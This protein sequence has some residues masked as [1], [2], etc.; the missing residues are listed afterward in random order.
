M[1]DAS[2]D[3]RLAVELESRGRNAVSAKRLGLDRLQDD[4][5]LPRLVDL[6]RGLD[7]MLITSDDNMPAEHGGLITSLGGIT[8]ATIDGQ[9]KGHGLEQEQWKCEVVHRW[10]HV[11]H[12]QDPLTI[13]RY[14]QASHRLWTPRRTRRKPIGHRVRSRQRR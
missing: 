3:H 10:V 14:S 8:V 13:R 4:V 1:V 6:H 11:M 7:W 5:L 12:D 9:W 2:L